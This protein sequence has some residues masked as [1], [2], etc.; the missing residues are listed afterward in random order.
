[1]VYI[2][3]TN[4][5]FSSEEL[6]YQKMFQNVDLSSNF[7]FSYSYDLTHT[8]QYNLYPP[9]RYEPETNDK[10]TAW[11]S[12]VKKKAEARGPGQT[13]RRMQPYKKFV[14]NEYLLRNVDM[15]PDWLLFIIYGFVSQSNIN[16]FGKPL[17]LT[18]IARR[19]QRF[20]GTRFLKRGANCHGYVG[21]EG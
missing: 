21:N 9:C 4:E 6:R 16:V 10:Q 7:Y 5:K 3:N 20:A 14:W 8:L 15:H 13:I 18:L 12:R 17:Y 11:E 2:P 19:S 1:M